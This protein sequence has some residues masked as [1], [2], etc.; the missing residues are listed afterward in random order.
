MKMEGKDKVTLM[1]HNHCANCGC[2]IR[3][4][5]WLCKDCRKEIKEDYDN[6]GR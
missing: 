6:D 3:F 2:V 4:Y 1:N 5:E